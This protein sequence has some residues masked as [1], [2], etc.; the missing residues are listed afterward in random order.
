MYYICI[1]RQFVSTTYHNLLGIGIHVCYKIFFD[2][3]LQP[4]KLESC[5]DYNYADDNTLLDEQDTHEELT[6]SMERDAEHVTQWFDC[7]GMKANQE[8][9][10]G[11]ALGTK[12]DH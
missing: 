10:Q 9:Y 4:N 3:H 1:Y 11:I 12:P 7:N 6:E 8:R 2:T 5:E